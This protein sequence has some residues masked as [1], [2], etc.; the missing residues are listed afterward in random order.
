MSM[1]EHQPEIKHSLNHTLNGE[2]ILLEIKIQNKQK[3][4][5]NKSTI[6]SLMNLNNMNHLS[7]I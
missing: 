4:I 2:E 5:S 7:G 3:I 6:N 1:E